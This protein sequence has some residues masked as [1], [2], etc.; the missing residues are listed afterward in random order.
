[1]KDSNPTEDM[2][3][4]GLPPELEDHPPGIDVETDPDTMFAPR[5][6]PIAAGQDPAYPITAEDQRAGE[7]VADR[8]RREEPDVGASELGVGGGVPGGERAG[9]RVDSSG[10]QIV[11]PSPADVGAGGGALTGERPEEGT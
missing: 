3:A 11:D 5:D 7:T 4:E 10:A 1:M 6:Y 2:E 9:P 8:A